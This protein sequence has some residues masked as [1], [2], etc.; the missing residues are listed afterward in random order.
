[1]KTLLLLTTM[2]FLVKCG[3]DS[4]VDPRTD[5][6]TVANKSG[7]TVT[8]IP[9]IN[10]NIDLGRKV[11]LE[12]NKSLN[13]KETFIDPNGGLGM[14][15]VIFDYKANPYTGILTHV[16]VVFGNNKKV[17]YKACSPT[18]NCNS[19]PRSIFNSEFNSDGTE[20]YTVTAEDYQ[21]AVD[22]GGNCY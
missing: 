2:T 19:N 22:C 9:Y 10:D 21:N 20:T 4:F 7:V 12:N 17:L 15:D 8:F 3:T 1:M 13:K 18:Y 16:E 6:Y 5:D 14:T 11:V